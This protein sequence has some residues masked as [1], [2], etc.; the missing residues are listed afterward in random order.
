MFEVKLFSCTRRV[1]VAHNFRLSAVLDY[2][3]KKRPELT[4]LRVFYYS[5][6]L[7]VAALFARQ[8]PSIM[9]ESL[10]S[11]QLKRPAEERR[12]EAIFEPEEVSEQRVVASSV[13][14]VLVRS[15]VG[16]NPMMMAQVSYNQLTRVC[17]LQFY[18]PD[19]QEVFERQLSL[20]EVE[21]GA[22]PNATLMLEARLDTEVGARILDNFSRKIYI[23]FLHIREARKLRRTEEQEEKK[24]AQA[25]LLLTPKE[26]VTPSI[27][28]AG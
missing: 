1:W 19:S 21:A 18:L 17:T 25:V 4:A 2:L 20:V 14:R 10:A 12:L 15:V 3:A 6:L 28:V 11:I 9:K 13:E 5:S 24:E 16:N 8:A 23:D 26:R 22:L 7:D 27:D